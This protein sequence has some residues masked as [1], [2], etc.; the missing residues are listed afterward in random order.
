MTSWLDEVL[1]VRKRQAGAG[2]GVE[3]RNM[4]ISELSAV[5]D[6]ANGVADWLLM[7]A[8]DDPEGALDLIRVDESVEKGKA[9]TV[10][11]LSDDDLD[12]AISEAEYA[13]A[14]D[15]DDGD[16]ADLL[17]TLRAEK[18]R[19]VAGAVQK[20]VTNLDRL[21]EDELLELREMVDEHPEEVESFFKR[22]SALHALVH[23]RTNRVDL[24]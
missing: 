4:Q 19:R 20:F 14:V 22:Q 1:G 10:K 3:L 8:A 13:A 17:K 12:D 9:A 5:D 11:N 24:T 7:K 6:P 2:H 21:S 15:P 23:G 16:I 18:N